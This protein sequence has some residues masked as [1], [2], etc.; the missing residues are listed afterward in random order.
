MSTICMVGLGRLGLPVACAFAERG[1]AVYGYELDEAKRERYGH[2]DSGLYEP[3]LDVLLKELIAEQSF[4]VCESLSGAVEHAEIIF[5]A[6]PTPSRSDHSFDTSYV[7]TALKQV[8]F[9]VNISSTVDYPVIALISTVLPETCRRE[10]LPLLETKLD[11]P[12]GF[13]YNAQFIAMGTVIDDALHPEFVLIGEQDERAGDVVEKFYR[14]TLRPEAYGSSVPPI[15]R[16]S[17]ENAEL[18]KCVYNNAISIKVVLGNTI[19]EMCDKIPNADCDV[20]IDALS[21]ATDRLISPKYL[22]GGYGDGGGC[23]PRDNR[24]LRYLAEQ[25]NLSA[26]PFAFVTDARVTQTNY[27]AEQVVALVHQTGYPIKLLGATFKPDTNRTDDSPSLLLA[28][29]LWLRHHLYVAIYDPNVTHFSDMYATETV[30]QLYVIGVNSPQWTVYPFVHGSVIYD[31]WGA[32]KTTPNG[33]RLVSVG[34]QLR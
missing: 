33:C 13:V 16:M 24:A 31:P 32:I 28:D 14:Y 26:N 17:L 8:A 27:L 11:R 4:N 21:F 25:L 22:R 20:V 23:H 19:M 9:A 34:R 18:T 1:N 12:F 7:L 2:G 5:I 29:M 10:F 6:V 3:G 30:P 15:Q